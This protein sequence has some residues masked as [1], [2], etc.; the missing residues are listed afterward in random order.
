M[1]IIHARP[2]VYRG[3]DYA[4]HRQLTASRGPRG[5]GARDP[6]SPSQRP[7]DRRSA[8]P[9]QVP[10]TARDAATAPPVRA[11][12]PPYRGCWH[13]LRSGPSVP[14]AESRWRAT[15]RTAPPVLPEATRRLRATTG[16]FHK[17]AR[18][19]NRAGS[20]HSSAEAALRTFAPTRRKLLACNR[21]HRS[22][23]A[24]GSHQATSRRHR[25]LPDHSATAQMRRKRPFVRR[26]CAQ[27]PGPSFPSAE[28][29]WR[30]TARTAPP[31]QREASRR[32]RATET[33][34]SNR[35]ALSI[36]RAA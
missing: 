3:P 8:K 13:H 16:G 7:A 34:S 2:P 27:D 21:T 23:G 32:P 31:V 25:W 36:S 4:D 33:N 17:T 19:R 9:I 20:V 24:T 29:R 1:R 10:A 14:S 15:A 28:S 12:R 11:Y 30:A 22:A 35:R 5:H 6:G 18:L 26:S